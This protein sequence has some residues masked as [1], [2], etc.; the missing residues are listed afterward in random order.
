MRSVTSVSVFVLKQCPVIVIFQL[1]RKSND[2][3]F[4]LKLSVSFILKG[5]SN[6]MCNSGWVK[7][8]LK[9]PKQQ[10]PDVKNMKVFIL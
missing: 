7:P 5:H 6:L 9:S 10:L 8:V 1:S 3:A 2:E 4:I